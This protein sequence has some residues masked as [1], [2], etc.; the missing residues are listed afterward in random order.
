VSDIVWED[1]PPAMSG[2]HRLVWADRLAPLRERPGEWANLGEHNTSIAVRIRQGRAGS[3][4]PGEFEATVRHA[5]SGRGRG[6][7]YVRYV[8]KAE[9]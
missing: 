1:P 3:C 8:G 7:I 2:G 6:T 9:S 5:D 4:A